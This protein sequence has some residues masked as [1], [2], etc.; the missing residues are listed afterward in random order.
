VSLET[1][2]SIFLRLNRTDTAAR[3]LAWDEFH[4]RYAPVIASFA[5]RLGV[6]PGDVDDVV[7]DVLVGF[8][9]A[10]PTFVYDPDKGRFRSYLKRCTCHVL[11]RRA[12]QRARQRA[13][14]AADLG[15]L[16]SIEVEHVWN[17]VWEQE[18][19][20]QAVEQL[21][22]EIGATKAFRAFELYVILDHAPQQVARQLGMHLD[23]VYRAKEQV[24]ARL[25]A[26]LRE[27]PD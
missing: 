17:D 20:R 16:D 13:G 9:A 4:A 18:R 12:A 7:Q 19:L 2:P 8:Y 3:G 24:T 10:S 6:R 15:D 26:A 27:R 25:R 11:S 22:S 14:R 23:S 1:N 21:R 5:R